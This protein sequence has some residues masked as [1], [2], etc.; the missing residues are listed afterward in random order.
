MKILKRDSIV[1]EEN[2]SLSFVTLVDEPIEILDKSDIYK[3]K[4]FF[5][6]QPNEKKSPY[7]SETYITNINN[8]DER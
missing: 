7:G 5:K 8:I 2:N 6:I 4:F 1:Q 3:I